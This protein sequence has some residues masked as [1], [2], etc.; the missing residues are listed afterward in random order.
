MSAL[1]LNFNKISAI[2]TNIF[3]IFISFIFKISKLNIF[4][5]KH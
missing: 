5:K 1:T 2:N 4:S 3:S